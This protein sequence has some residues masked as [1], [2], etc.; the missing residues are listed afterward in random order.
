MGWWSVDIMGGDSPLD[1]KAMI[2]E[3][4]EVV[5]YDDKYEDEHKIPNHKFDYDKVVDFLDDD[6]EYWLKSEGNIFHQ[7]LG[8]MMLEAGAVIDD[9]LKAKMIEAAEKDE[10]A[11]ED[12]ERK[13]RMNSFIKTLNEYDNETPM[14]IKSAGLFDKLCVGLTKQEEVSVDTLRGLLLAHVEE[15]RHEDVNKILD[16]IIE[17]S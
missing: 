3:A 10:W 12:D 14:I 16:K 2:F 17:I 6:D 4:L 1:I 13:Q 9:N 11:S 5:Q 15:Y 8:V 7:V